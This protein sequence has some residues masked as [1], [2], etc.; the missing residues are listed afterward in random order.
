MEFSFL[1][2]TDNVRGD[3]SLFYSRH[4]C[5]GNPKEEK[6]EAQKFGTQPIRLHGLDA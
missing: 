1:G 4:R 5:I 2:P 6:I 3:E